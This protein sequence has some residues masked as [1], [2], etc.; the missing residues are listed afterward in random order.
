MACVPPSSKGPSTASDLPAVVA[1]ASS[2]AAA[3]AAAGAPPAVAPSAA[4]APP[5]AAKSSAAVASPAVGALPVVAALPDTAVFPG[6]TLSHAVAPPSAAHQSSVAPKSFVPLSSMGGGAHIMPPPSCAALLY[7][8]LSLFAR[9]A[10]ADCAARSSLSWSTAMDLST[11]PMTGGSLTARR[12][13]T[14]HNLKPLSRRCG[15]Q[16]GALFC[17]L[18]RR[19][20]QVQKTRTRTMVRRA[21][22]VLSV[23]LFRFI[24]PPCCCRSR[25]SPW[26]GVLRPPP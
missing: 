14:A 1:S 11:T 13:T 25:A 16:S 9:H 2:A 26:A 17:W 6:A 7:S 19:R 3:S 12:T 4:V 18:P 8:A 20:G 15:G 21:Q 10:H 24:T 5:A 22:V 23:L